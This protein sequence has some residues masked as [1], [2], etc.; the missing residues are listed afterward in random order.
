MNERIN[1][2][3]MLDGSV[4]YLGPSAF[5]APPLIAIEIARAFLHEA[6]VE[7]IF[8]DPGQTV[9]RPKNGNGG[10]LIR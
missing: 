2:K 7:V 6:G 1:I 8:A 5:N 10:E 9:I 3:R 4:Q